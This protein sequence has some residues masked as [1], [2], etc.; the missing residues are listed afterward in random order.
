[1]APELVADPERV[2]EKAD[3]WSM[4]VVMW[5]MLMR[6]MPYQVGSPAPVPG[7]S[8]RKPQPRQC[9]PWLGPHLASRAHTL[10]RLAWPCLAPSLSPP[11]C[12]PACNGPRHTP[13]LATSLPAPAAPTPHRTSPRS[14]S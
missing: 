13:D 12:L 2:S 11:Q 6:E 10:A 3:V 1:M 4:G 8:A 14:K 9:Q 7:R 5:E